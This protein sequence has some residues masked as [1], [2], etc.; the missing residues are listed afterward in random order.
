MRIAVTCDTKA[1][2]LHY[3]NNMTIQVT[4]P[5]D[6]QAGYTFEASTSDGKPVSALEKKLNCVCTTAVLLC[7]NCFRSSP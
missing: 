1:T 5:S 4:A 7:S 6:L 2:P 3:H